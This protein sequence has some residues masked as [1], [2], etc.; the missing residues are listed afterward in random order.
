VI[1]AVILPPASGQCRIDMIGFIAGKFL[2]AD[3]T[4][5]QQTF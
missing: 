1:A 4:Y 2:A 3:R 5:L